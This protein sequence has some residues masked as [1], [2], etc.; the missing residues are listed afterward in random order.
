[1]TWAP[2]PPATHPINYFVPDF[3]VDEDVVRTQ[4]NLAGT[5]GIL[6]HKLVIP[7]VKPADPPHFP[8]NLGLN[9]DMVSSLQNLKNQEAAYGEWTLP[10]PE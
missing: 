1:M 10:P 4:S 6:D 9:E 7:E 5:E 2:T 3:G 8:P